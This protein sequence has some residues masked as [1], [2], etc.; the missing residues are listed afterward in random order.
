LYGFSSRSWLDGLLDPEQIISPH[1]FGATAHAQKDEN[2]DFREGGMVQ[3]VHD[4]L[5]GLDEPNRA[6]L[7]QVIAALSAEAELPSQRDADESARNDGTLEKG[8]DALVN[9]FGCI[10]CHRFH[11]DGDL[12][13]APDLTGYG[14][15]EWLT[16]FIANPEGERFYP[17]SNDRMP[18]FAPNPDVPERNRLTLDEIDILARWIRGEPYDPTP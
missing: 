7:S 11:D 12:G 3:F 17:D 10:D 18:A 15:H 1:Y 16:Q 4:N 2:G 13:Y 5:V 14:S 6:A 9:N 8:R